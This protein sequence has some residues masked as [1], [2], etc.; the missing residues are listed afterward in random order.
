MECPTCRADAKSTERRPDGNSTCVN[1][2]THPTTEFQK[3]DV[4]NDFDHHVI[5]YSKS[6]WYRRT[7][8]MAD[9]KTLIRKTCALSDDSRIPDPDV[10]MLVAGT[11]NK[12][13]SIGKMNESDT[14]ILYKDLWR[15]HGGYGSYRE[16]VNAEDMIESFLRVLHSKML[17]VLPKPRKPNPEY[18]PLFADD[19]LE[20]F[21]TR[22]KDLPNVLMN[23]NKR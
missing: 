3:F 10:V 22:M 17:N 23:W 6:T 12:V 18:L 16:T 19:T 5:L 14:Q 8:I 20:V 13:F 4:F 9:I 1:G 15:T 7:T 21:E 11:M 2:H